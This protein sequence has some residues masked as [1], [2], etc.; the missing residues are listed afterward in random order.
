MALID[1]D[2]WQE[3][4]NSLRRH[5]L[6]TLLTAFGVAWGIF[7]LVLMFGAINGLITSFE[8]DFR[9]DAVNS[10]WLWT[11]LLYTSPSPRDATLSRMPS[12]A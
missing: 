4:F 2:K 9:D 8:Y 10:L 5:P 12:S 3:I 6:R 11:C 7:T 1:Y